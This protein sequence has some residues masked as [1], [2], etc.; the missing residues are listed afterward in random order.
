MERVDRD[1][2]ALRLGFRQ[3]RGLSTDGAEIVAARAANPSSPST[4][5][6]PMCRSPPQLA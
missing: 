6:G 5:S 1:G 3:V 4:I 2:F